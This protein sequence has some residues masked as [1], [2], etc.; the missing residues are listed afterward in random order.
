MDALAL[1]DDSI[2]G[3][4]KPTTW[5]DIGGL[6]GAKGELQDTLQHVQYLKKFTKLSL[7]PFPGMLLY[8]PPGC[9][10]SML[11][12][13]FANEWQ[14]KLIHITNPTLLTQVCNELKATQTT[15]CVLLLD[16]LDTWASKSSP[17]INQI[18]TEIDGASVRKNVIMIGVT[19]RPDMVEP[20]IMRPGRLSQRIYVPIPDAPARVAIIKAQLKDA[21]LDKDVSLD[22]I[23]EK[24]SGY[25]G[26][27]LTEICQRVFLLAASAIT[28]DH[29]E[30]AINA[31]SK[32]LSDVDIQ[33]YEAYHYSLKSSSQFKFPENGSALDASQ[34]DVYSQNNNSE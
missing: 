32:S 13:A 27:D 11:A 15:P 10:K 7:P 30:T 18:I 9:G 23:A 28:R 22:S 24:T 17:S 33:K 20:D 4:D 14:A 5:E 8:G 34:D 6:E 3:A 29:F 25:S 19:A 1:Q 16:E 21:V 12:K 2:S 26:C 31:V